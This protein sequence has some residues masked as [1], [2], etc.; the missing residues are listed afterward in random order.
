[1]TN[2]GIKPEA[3]KLIRN[4]FENGMAPVQELVTTLKGI[5]KSLRGINKSLAELTKRSKNRKI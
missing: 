4:I 5:E 2:V 1:M 3:E